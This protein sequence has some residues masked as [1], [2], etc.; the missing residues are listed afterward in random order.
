MCLRFPIIVSKKAGPVHRMGNE[1][2][3]IN[4]RY[5]R[6]DK[7]NQRLQRDQEFEDSY[8]LDDES[9]GM[10]DE[11]YEPRPRRRS[12]P[13]RLQ[14]NEYEMSP[15]P[16]QPQ[17]STPGT[18]ATIARRGQQT[19]RPRQR[20]W[21]NLL[22]GCG[23][24]ALTAIIL[25]GGVFFFLFRSLQGVTG[26]PLPIPGIN[27]GKTYTQ[28]ERVIVP[29][30]TI[31]QIGICNKS[32]NVTIKVDPN[33][34]EVSVSPT[35]RVMAGSQEDA[36]Q[37][38]RNI[39][40]DIQPPGTLNSP[41]GCLIEGSTPQAENTATA[42]A[43][44]NSIDA[45][46]S[47]LVNVTFPENNNPQ[48]AVDL[49]VILPPNVLPAD[50]SA[51][52]DVEAPRGNIFIE[53]VPGRL[54]I[55][56]GI[57]EGNITVTRSTLSNGSHLSTPSGK[58]TFD[59]FLASPPPSQAEGEGDFTYILSGKQIEVTLPQNYKIKL[60]ARTNNGKITSDFPL[61]DDKFVKEGDY[62][63]YSGP[64][65]PSLGEPDNAQLSLLV[66]GIGDISIK[67]QPV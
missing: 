60:N 3:S 51:A 25:V 42:Q 1:R 39:S 66:G 52:I 14:Q 31:T 67:Q 49:I 47:L 6:I 22:I 4:R 12:R 5:R 45:A 36:D 20:G 21:S 11:E 30:S 54:T 24:G 23:I 48:N 2:N 43:T 13:A 46:A 19:R 7:Q 26:L 9:A 29:L 10:L 37:A 27:E 53:G 64:L 40:V 28:A 18:G 56:A 33:A 16:R 35:W 44:E 65:N 55:R 58:I 61:Q 50:L 41:F 59:G 34:T 15:A 17:R 32:G 8:D 38:F 62:V 63:S 57:N